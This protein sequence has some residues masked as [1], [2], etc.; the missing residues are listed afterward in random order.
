[1]K[2]NKIVAVNIAI[3]ILLAQ[4]AWGADEF[5]SIPSKD[6]S[7]NGSYS[8]NG[9]SGVDLKDEVVPVGPKPDVESSKKCD[10]DIGN[11]LYFPLKF[12]NKISRD[13]SGLTIKLM[14]GNKIQVIVPFSIK[15]CGTFYPEPYENP[16][17]KDMTIR[18]KV[19]P[20]QTYKE[21]LDC[22]KSEKVVA[23]D[24]SET[25]VT[26]ILIK[27]GEKYLPID[28]SK[29]S[30]DQYE[31]TSYSVRSTF[32][33]K[34]D[35]MKMVK[36]SYGSPNG[37]GG[38]SPLHAV[39]ESVKLPDCLKA[40]KIGSEIVYINEGRERELEK[41]QEICRSGSANVILKKL[42][43]GD[44][45]NTAALVGTFKQVEAE[46]KRAYLEK[47]KGDE[48]PKIYNQMTTIENDI[49][50]NIDT[51]TEDRARKRT[52]EYADLAK[53]LNKEFLVPSLER[54]SS[55]V[56]QADGMSDDNEKKKK[57]MAEIKILNEDIGAFDNRK[58]DL[59]SVSIIMK[60]YA[61]LDTAKTIQDIRLKS[62][63]YAKV[64]S[65]SNDGDKDALT[66]EEAFRRQNEG[67]A[68]FEK[69]LA[70]WDADYRSG[71]GES[72]PKSRVRNQAIAAEKDRIKHINNFYKNEEKNEKKACART[73]FRNPNN[74]TNPNGFLNPERCEDFYASKEARFKNQERRS[75]ADSAYV[76]KLNKRYAKMDASYNSYHRGKAQKIKEAG[77]ER[78]DP[79][80]PSYDPD[81]LDAPSEFDDEYTGWNSRQPAQYDPRMYNMGNNGNFSYPQYQGN[82]QFQGGFQQAPWPSL[83]PP[84]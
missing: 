26:P 69:T 24:G 47:Y 11:S 51:M 79:S 68:K 2:K 27:K 46:F 30:A 17:T 21:Y 52:R 48:L 34:T 49:T 13:G 28:H 9:S 60:K 14:P 66:F 23:Q 84:R 18:M 63:L 74:P 38:F 20:K 70:I 16:N 19:E 77:E 29:I 8:G 71:H 10:G 33:K 78:D 50:K 67:M 75:A 73:F 83:V 32:D 35:F 76:T 58:K 41:L 61:L 22:L 57:I 3:G 42:E 55:L 53:K 1:M 31:T 15:R 44:I 45:G 7:S 43:S 56:A 5:D 64:H 25:A 80:D 72:G 12:F 37:I 59:R 40:E 81:Y 4:L 62:F 39:D 54:L 65:D 36:L 82:Q 6:Y